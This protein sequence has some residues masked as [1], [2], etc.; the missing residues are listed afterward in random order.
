MVDHNREI[1]HVVL[2]VHILIA[3]Q[4]AA[5]GDPDVVV[6]AGEVIHCSGEQLKSGILAAPVAAPVT[7]ALDGAVLD[8]IKQLVCR[9]KRA[10]RIVGDGEAS[11]GQLA[12][13]LGEAL[14]TGEVNIAVTPGGTHLPGDDRQITAAACNCIGICRIHHAAVRGIAAAGQ[15]KGCCTDCTAKQ[16][17]HQSFDFHLFSLLVRFPLSKTPFCGRLRTNWSCTRRGSR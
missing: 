3:L 10:L 4:A 14:V 5:L 12:D 13:Q 11:V 8:V 9:T 7:A 2:A 1:R 15:T 6:H 16:T 17:C